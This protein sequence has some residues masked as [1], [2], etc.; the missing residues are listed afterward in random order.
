MIISNNYSG[1]PEQ[2]ASSSVPKQKATGNSV[3]GFESVMDNARSIGASRMESSVNSDDQLPLEAFALPSWYE[4]YLP[5][6]TNLTTELNH[7]YFELRNELTKDNILSDDERGQLKNYLDNDPFHQAQ[8]E[9]REFRAEYQDE[10][11]EYGETLNTY[12]KEALEENGVNS[13]RE[14]YENVL[15]DKEN[16]DKIHQSMQSRIESNPRVLELMEILGTTL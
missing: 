3:N 6:A 15:L 14:Y 10:I 9:K 1:Q 4:S 11:S 13:H 2:V 7:D 12:F 16:S 8:I 5:E